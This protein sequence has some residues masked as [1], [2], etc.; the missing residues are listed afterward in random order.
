M[1]GYV[2]AIESE[3]RFT[4][5]RVFKFVLNNGFGTRIQVNCWNEHIERIK[6]KVIMD[7]IIYLEKAHCVTSTDYNRGNYKR[8]E[9]IINKFTNVE[10]M[11][12]FN[13]ENCEIPT[14][15]PVVL[16]E[17]QLEDLEKSILPWKFK[18][19]GYLKTQFSKIGSENPT[20][21]KG[22]FTITDG[23]RKL[24]VTTNFFS[25]NHEYV[26]GDSLQL[27]GSI[28]HLSE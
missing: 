1:I 4:N 20:Q 8:A 25:D 3:M 22:I 14:A 12:A 19:S 2:D 23:I 10:I 6:E 24:D 7:N 18:I 28:F 17:F 11:G 26:R 15:E 27:S 16:Q 21:V 9:L 13:D 5:S